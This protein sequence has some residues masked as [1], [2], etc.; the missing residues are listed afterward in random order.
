MSMS[1]STPL[2]VTQESQGH[3]SNHT[4]DVESAE[5][6]A[7]VEVPPP[8]DAKF[9]ILK[10]AKLNNI[11]VEPDSSFFIQKPRGGKDAEYTTIKE[12]KGISV[13]NITLPTFVLQHSS[14]SIS[15]HHLPLSSINLHLDSLVSITSNQYLSVPVSIHQH[16][17]ASIN[18]QHYS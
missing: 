1:E 16:L 3:C 6:L 2:I 17:L 9:H 15:I 11:I 4:A 12:I 10:D 13:A 18:I 5:E 8:K 14:L 7:L